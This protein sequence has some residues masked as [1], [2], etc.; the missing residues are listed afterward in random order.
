MLLSILFSGEIFMVRIT[1]ARNPKW[2]TADHNQIIIDLFQENEWAPFVADPTD[3]TIHGVML[4]HFCKD[5]LFGKIDD[6]DEEKIL[7]GR[8]PCQRV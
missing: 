3:C 7:D 5:E 8:L 4:F 1:K 2:T 6:S